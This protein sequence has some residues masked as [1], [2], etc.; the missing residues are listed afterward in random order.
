MPTAETETVLECVVGR[1]A[2]GK[3]KTSQ[4]ATVPGLYVPSK[5]VFL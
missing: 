1:A 5:T 4:H 2:E 3:N